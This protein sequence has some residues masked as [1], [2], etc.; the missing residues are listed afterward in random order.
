MKQHGRMVNEIIC[1]VSP[2]RGLSFDTIFR[3]QVNDAAC[4]KSQAF[5]S[6]LTFQEPVDTY[7]SASTRVRIAAILAHNF[8]LRPA[9]TFSAGITPPES[10][11]GLIHLAVLRAW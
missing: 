11:R 10:L 2:C 9:G 8:C 6:D 5:L 4:K 3:M 7:I 1:P